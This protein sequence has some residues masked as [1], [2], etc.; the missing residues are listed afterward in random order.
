MAK[1]KHHPAGSPRALEIDPAQGYLEG[2]ITD[3]D[4]IVKKY[5]VAWTGIEGYVFAARVGGRWAN[6]HPPQSFY[7]WAYPVRFWEGIDGVVEKGIDA[8][9]NLLIR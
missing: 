9:L 1:S 5:Y 3:P 6:V 8:P 4:E 2:Y 7:D